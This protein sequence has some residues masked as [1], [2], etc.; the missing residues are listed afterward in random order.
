MAFILRFRLKM[1]MKEMRECGIERECREKERR[2]SGK[3]EE[4]DGKGA[5]SEEERY[6][7]SLNLRTECSM[8]FDPEIK[9]NY[10]L[11]PILMLLGFEKISGTS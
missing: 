11:I 5:E 4:S 2:D 1:K 9:S 6:G 7:L 3:I 10:R 8:N